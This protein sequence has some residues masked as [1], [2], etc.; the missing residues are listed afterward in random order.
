ML[1]PQLAGPAQNTTDEFDLGFRGQADIGIPLEDDLQRC[2]QLTPGQVHAEA[3]MDSSAEADQFAVV[4][5]R[6]EFARIGENLGIIVG[7]RDS[8]Q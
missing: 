2:F 4:A 8:E 7:R 3:K 5:R 1:Y 6:V